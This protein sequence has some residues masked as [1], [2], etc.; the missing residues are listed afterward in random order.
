MCG[1]CGEIRFDGSHPPVEILR[2]MNSVL[3]PRG[4]D[5]GGLFQMNHIAAGHR[6]LKIIDLSEH[7]QQPMVDNELGLG[8]VFNGCIY[9]FR[10]LRAELRAL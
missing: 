1:I 4:P 9:N 2:A 3:V 8:L 7:A 5:A 6:R 10:E